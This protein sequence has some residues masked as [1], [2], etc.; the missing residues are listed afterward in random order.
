MQ[1]DIVSRAR[2]DLTGSVDEKTK[3][4]YSRFFKEEVK[5]YG[6]KSSTVGKIAKDYFKELQQAGKADKRNI[7][8][9]KN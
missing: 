3:N 7:L 4:S 1:T 6:V 2:K 5:C 9:V 8:K